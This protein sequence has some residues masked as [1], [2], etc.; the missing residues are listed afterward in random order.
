[1]AIR[2][3]LLSSLLLLVAPVAASAQTTAGPMTVTESVGGVQDQQINIAECSG[4]GL[5]TVDL[6]WSLSP[7]T[8]PPTN[9]VFRI[10]AVTG[11]DC[12]STTATPRPQLVTPDIAANGLTTGSATGIH[13]DAIPKGLSLSCAA[14]TTVTINLC[15]ILLTG[16]NGTRVSPIQFASTTINLDTRVPAKPTGVALASGDGALSVS[17]TAPSGTPAATTYRLKAV[18][19]SSYDPTNPGGAVCTGTPT[20]KETGDASTSYRFTGLAN[21]TYYAVS[22]IAL[23]AVGNPSDAS[24]AAYERPQPV[25]DFWRHYKNQGG[26]EEGG[27]GSGGAGLL[28]LLLLAPL[29]PRLRRRRL[30][31]GAMA[32]VLLLAAAPAWAGPT[33]R[34]GS[35]QL[36]MSGY[37]PSIDSEFSGSARPYQD[38]FGTGRG[39]TFRGGFSRALFSRWGSLEVGAGIGWFSKSGR[40]FV[41]GTAGTTRSSDRTEL[42]ILPLSLSLAYRLDYF[43]DHGGFPLV[44]YARAS[45]ERWQWWVTNGSGNTASVVGGGASGSGATSGWSAGLGLSFLLDFLDPVLAREMD[46]DTGINHAYVFAEASRSRVNDFGSKK[47][48]NLSDDAKVSWSFGLHFSF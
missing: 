26:R 21:G 40:G 9:A 20:V 27:C 16:P 42:R 45:L 41:S 13:I 22:V 12:A 48:W 25:D 3:A 4:D 14:N 8:T 47:S 43:V 19:C 18:S 29:A 10:D 34:W 33:E 6:A 23:S 37:R 24:T 32:L 5:S 28:A 11:G 31:K 15:A 46:R 38:V 39:W 36:E 7:T 17:W 2:T 35:F 44:P 1:M 30:G